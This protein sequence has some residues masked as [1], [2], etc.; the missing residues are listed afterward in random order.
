[1]RFLML[2][3]VIAAIVVLPFGCGDD[4]IKFP[5]ADDTPTPTVTATVGSATQ[6]PTQT[7]TVTPTP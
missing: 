4:D 1:M 7:P 6:T 5:G 3:L 2:T